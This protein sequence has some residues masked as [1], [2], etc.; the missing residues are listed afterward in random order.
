M[1]MYRLSQKRTQV[2][3]VYNLTCMQLKYF[4]YIFCNFFFFNL[5][6]FYFTTY[7]VYLSRQVY[8]IFIQN[9]LKIDYHLTIN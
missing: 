2:N 7:K 8:D 3:F 9:L 4:M 5:N 1:W 6:L